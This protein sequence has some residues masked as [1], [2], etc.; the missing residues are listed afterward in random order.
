MY[1]GGDV[2]VGGHGEEGLDGLFGAVVYFEAE[3]LAEIFF[4]EV[5][6]PAGGGGAVG[7]DPVDAG[8]VFEHGALKD[9]GGGDDVDS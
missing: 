2:E 9:M 7:D 4:G 6:W 5:G 3:E 1:L 8:L